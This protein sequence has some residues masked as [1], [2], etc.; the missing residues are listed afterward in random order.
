MQ[1]VAGMPCAEALLII[2]VTC[3]LNMIEN[4]VPILKRETCLVC[5]KFILTHNCIIARQRCTKM[6]HVQTIFSFHHG[7]WLCNQCTVNN[8]PTYNP[9]DGTNNDKYDQFNLQNFPN[10]E[11]MQKYCQ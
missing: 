10:F 7:K 5:Q 2:M 6:Y 4:N 1:D 11:F 3:H 9:F 8:C